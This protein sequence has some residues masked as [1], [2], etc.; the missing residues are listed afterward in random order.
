MKLLLEYPW[1]GNVRELQNAVA[2]VCAM[3]Q[4]ERIGS[5]LLPSTILRHFNRQRTVGGVDVDFPEEGLDLRAL[6]FDVERGYYEEALRI[7]SG[8]AER[9]AHLLGINGPAFRKAAR[10]RLGISYGEEPSE[11]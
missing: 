3:G 11:S 6:L 8:N 1:P 5:E 4:S 7:T 10:E 2:S 9:A